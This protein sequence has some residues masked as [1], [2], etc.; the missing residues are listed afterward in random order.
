MVQAKTEAWEQ[1]ARRTLAPKIASSAYVITINPSDEID[2]K[3]ALE[4]GYAV[5]LGKPIILVSWGGRDVNP[6]LA[7]IA[8]RHIALSSPLSTPAGQ[9]ELMAELGRVF[10]A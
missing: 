9:Q 10:D 8:T 7:R 6:G 4:T 1:H 3:I 2:P 5:L